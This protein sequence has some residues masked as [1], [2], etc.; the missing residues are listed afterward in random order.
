MKG[1]SSPGKKR[2]KMT[3]KKDKKS[4][5][6]VVAEKARVKMNNLSDQE[7]E[8]LMSRAMQIIY[9][10]GGDEACVSRR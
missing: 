2:R 7:R 4:K 9:G 8:A 6:T 3:S 10:K 1:K 5:G